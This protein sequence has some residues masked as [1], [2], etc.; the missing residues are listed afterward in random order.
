MNNEMTR[1]T[2]GAATANYRPR[3]SFYH[4]NGKGT[5]CA[6]RL[7]LHPAHDRT[8]GSIMMSVANQLTVGDR[9]GPNPVFP[10][11][12]WD[13]K[14]TVKLDF[15]DLSKM[16]Q[17]F[18][19]ECESLEEGKGLY[20][21]APNFTTRIVLRHVIEPTPGYSIELYRTPRS[22][23]DEIRTHLLLS[24]WEALGLAESIT[25]SLACISFGIPTVIPRD[26]SEYEAKVREMRDV[27][28]A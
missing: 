18:R 9:R 15:T 8:D 2:K 19:G 20:H 11:F 10:R 23:E 24:P 6:M 4:P 26:T 13:N 5:G 17:V 16:L 27:T 12:D 14:I 1:E 7:E 3:L 22:G 28:A 21:S 25:G